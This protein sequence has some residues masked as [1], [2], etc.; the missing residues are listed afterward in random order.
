MV[1]LPDA[2]PHRWFAAGYFLAWIGFSLAATLVQ[3]MLQREALLDP[4]MASA[5]RT[6]AAVVLIAA[7]IYQ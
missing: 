7:G 1:E 6:L 2:D 3:W 4:R 5:S